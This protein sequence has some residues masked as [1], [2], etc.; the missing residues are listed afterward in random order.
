MQ[1]RSKMNWRGTDPRYVDHSSV[2]E[3]IKV[4]QIIIINIKI[5]LCNFTYETILVFN[6]NN[7]NFLSFQVVNVAFFIP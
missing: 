2:Q 7:I 3:A 6:P 5:Y 1:D 4:Q